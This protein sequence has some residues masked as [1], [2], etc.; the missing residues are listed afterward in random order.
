MLEW[1]ALRALLWHR[2]TERPIHRS[3]KEHAGSAR[4]RVLCSEMSFPGIVGS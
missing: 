2:P 4:S 3:P 1:R